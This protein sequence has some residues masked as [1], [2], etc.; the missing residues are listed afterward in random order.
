MAIWNSNKKLQDMVFKLYRDSDAYKIM[1]NYMLDKQ[2]EYEK[3]GDE[4]FLSSDEKLELEKEYDREET[5]K[6][7][8]QLKKEGKYDEYM[9]NLIHKLREEGK[10]ERYPL[11]EFYKS[12]NQIHTVR[13]LEETFELS[14]LTIRNRWPEF[15]NMIKYVSEGKRFLWLTLRYD[16]LVWIITFDL[17]DQTTRESINFLYKS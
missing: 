15:F 17:I 8:E 4:D 7:E 12:L 13:D 3:C 9:N 10:L 16:I 1:K 6:F 14:Y 5:E 11:S 2:E